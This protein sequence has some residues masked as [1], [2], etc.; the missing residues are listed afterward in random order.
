MGQSAGHLHSPSSP[1]P[2][3]APK[4]A[5]SGSA[6]LRPTAPEALYD[7][8]GPLPPF[9]LLQPHQADL[10]QGLCTDFPQQW[11]CSDPLATPILTIVL[12]LQPLPPLAPPPGGGFNRQI[13]F[14]FPE[15]ERHR[16]HPG[17]ESVP[18]G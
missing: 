10:R 14:H 9:T 2:P 11:L 13:P 16:E 5:Q 18:A 1:E 8:R 12:P 7:L 4:S 6:R 17:A 15:L 3:G